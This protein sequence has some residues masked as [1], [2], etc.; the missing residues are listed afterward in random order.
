MKAPQPGISGTRDYAG[1]DA[2]A[3]QTARDAIE[4]ALRRYAYAAVDPPIL[5]SPLPFLNRS[6]EDIRRRMYIFPDPGGRE[7]CLRPEL[8][9][10]VCRAYLRGSQSGAQPRAAAPEREARLSYFG[11]AFT[12]E[13]ASDGRY[14]QF[15]QAGAEFIG[16]QSREAADAEILAAALDCLKATGLTQTAIEIGDV[17]IRNA[18]IDNLPI[19]ERSK[20]RIRRIT[21][22]NQKASRAA[23]LSDVSETDT[24][25]GPNEFA[26]LASLLA[27]V[28]ASKA[29]LLIRDV[30]A[31]AD[32]RHVGGRTPEEILERLTSRTAQ[33]TEPIS[34][35]LIQGVMALLN[36]RAK[37]EA[38]FKTIRNHFR[39]FGIA[40][41]ESVL[42]RCERR[43]RY[44]EAYGRKPDTLQFNVGLRRGLEYYTGFMFEIFAKG[45]AQIGHVCGGGRYDNL[46]EGLGAGESIPAVGFGIGLDRL[47]LALQDDNDAGR[48]AVTAPQALVVATGTDDQEQC[49]RV[50]ALLR[51]AGWSVEFEASARDE[52]S[53]LSYASQRKIHCVVFA[54]GDKAREDEV[55]IRRP[56]DRT[57]QRVAISALP[58]YAKRE[59]AKMAPGGQP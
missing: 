39:K 28:D 48:P 45:A 12:Y 42:E 29:E 51:A 17:D 23:S 20:T 36:I 16:A 46:L 30:F 3:L 24:A 53:A 2:V 55:R 57:E 33:Q 56:S 8:T 25:Q 38:A 35:E 5:E 52:K 7:V 44:I 10:P 47:L 9:I 14:R 22:R 58:D 54:G 43:L 31:L 6:G 4:A 34:A 1:E 50:S 40:S 32:V 21:L 15:Y 49:I 18:F 11:P 19:S 27:S 41:V 13:S 37:P 26:A 59:S